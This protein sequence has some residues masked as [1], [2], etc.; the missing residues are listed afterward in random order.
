MTVFATS[1]CRSK[2]RLTASI[3][4]SSSSSIRATGM[5]CASTSI[6]A[7]TALSRVGNAHAAEVI[8][9]GVG[10]TRSVISVI[11]PSVPSLPM[12]RRVR[13]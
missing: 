9:S 1:S 12:N 8:D 2:W 6:T 11:S 5:A 4:T 3:W 10:W 7:S 13:S